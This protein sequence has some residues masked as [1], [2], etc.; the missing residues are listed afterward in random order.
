MGHLL[1][2]L[3]SNRCLRRAGR[4]LRDGTKPGHQ[5]LELPPSSGPFRL[6]QA[7]T[8][9]PRDGFYYA[10]IFISSSDI[11]LWCLVWAGAGGGDIRSLSQISSHVYIYKTSDRL[12]KFVVCSELTPHI[13][14]FLAGSS[15]TA[16]LIKKAIFFPLLTLRS[17]RPF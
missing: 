8:N 1:P 15:H 6:L 7:P 13:F 14:N 9:R 12:Q 5:R 4:L 10:F 2:F 16:D 11:S 17:Q 3:E